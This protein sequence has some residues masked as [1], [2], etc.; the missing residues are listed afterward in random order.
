M[1]IER[2]L[3]CEL[4]AKKTSGRI[5]FYQ[6]SKPKVGGNESE[7]IFPEAIGGN[8]SI[9]P[10]PAELGGGNKSAIDDWPGEISALTPLR[11]DS[12]KSKQGK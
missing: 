11:S 4:K 12:V 3:F 7:I 9:I 10:I 5:S 1:E 2:W 6:D 8:R